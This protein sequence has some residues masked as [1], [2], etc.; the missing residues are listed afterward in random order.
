MFFIFI[1]IIFSQ[2]SEL[3][4]SYKYDAKG[5]SIHSFLFNP[6]QKFSP[7][8]DRML[9]AHAVYRGD[10]GV[11]S[12]IEIFNFAKYGNQ[13][14][15]MPSEQFFPHCSVEMHGFIRLRSE[16]EAAFPGLGLAALQF[17][18]ETWIC[19]YRSRSRYYPTHPFF[20]FLVFFC[21]SPSFQL[22]EIMRGSTREHSE[23]LYTVRLAVEM[24]VGFQK[25]KFPI[26]LNAV[27]RKTEKP[28]EVAICTVL[29]FKAESPKKQ[30]ID[31]ALLME[32][33]KHHTSLGLNLLVF[34]RDGR[35]F[36][37][38]FQNP[39]FSSPSLDKFP[40]LHYF[41]NTM[42]G[43]L[44]IFE[45]SDH[46]MIPTTRSKNRN[47]QRRLIDVDRHM[48]LTH[49]RAKAL[50]EFGIDKVLVIDFDEFLF[51]PSAK[52]TIKSQKDYFNKF[53][54]SRAITEGSEQHHF[55][56]RF[57]TNR[58][59]SVEE[60]VYSKLQKIKQMKKSLFDKD[61]PSLFD[62]WAPFRFQSRYVKKEM[63]SMHMGYFCPWT[64]QFA[65]CY[66][67]KPNSYDYRFMDC[68]CRITSSVSG[69][70]LLHLTTNQKMYELRYDTALLPSSL[71]E[72]EKLELWHVTQNR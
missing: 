56:S 50:S 33:I 44:D 61:S 48:T 30:S 43:V 57:L 58:T 38:A 7:W 49:C 34:D 37:T 3:I 66:E 47:S 4:S 59:S 16:N 18:E 8:V 11:L 36:P 21:P 6:Y 25:I 62:C 55:H 53:Y 1:S 17:Y 68:Q 46:D 39:F 24:S 15:S 41:N 71:S 64:N 35:N 70:L 63:K 28:D 52:L 19:H 42:A 72:N 60:C 45:I 14:F 13:T 32:W 22:C 40:N 12:E 51:C 20:R 27:T 54:K 31:G 26:N 5:L 2:I 10:N 9:G 23:A 67:F 69:C 29:P 65:S